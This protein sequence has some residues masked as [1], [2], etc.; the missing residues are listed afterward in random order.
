[1]YHVGLVLLDE[2]VIKAHVYE[3]LDGSLAHSI[4]AI[5]VS[6]ELLLFQNE[7]LDFFFVCVCVCLTEEKTDFS[8][9][10]PRLLNPF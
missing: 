3:D 9:M 10:E 4:A 1:M 8:E 7:R 6:W 5:L 2:L